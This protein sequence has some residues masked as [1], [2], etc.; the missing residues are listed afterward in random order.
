MRAPPR[1]V[2]GA[3]PTGLTIA[4]ELALAGVHCQVLERRDGLRTDS[5]AI[6]MPGAW[7]CSTCAAWPAGSPPRGPGGAGLAVRNFPLGLKGAAIDLARLDSDFP[8]LL[9]MPQSDIERLLGTPPVPTQTTIRRQAARRRQT[10]QA[11]CGQLRF[12]TCLLCALL[13]APA[14]VARF[15]LRSGG[16]LSS[17]RH[18]KRPGSRQLSAA[19]PQTCSVPVSLFPSLSCRGVLPGGGG[20]AR[21]G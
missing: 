3:G 1:N 8:Y 20:A 18:G 17:C 21:L 15:V 12:V 13:A 6:S 9:D 2:V 19:S 5:R 14:H 4:A 10:L 16:S 7:R 11:R